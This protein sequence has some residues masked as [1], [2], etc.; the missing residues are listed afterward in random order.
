MVVYVQVSTEARRH[1][2]YLG[3][4][5]CCVDVVGLIVPGV[6][7]CLPLSARHCAALI[8]RYLS[9]NMITTITPGAL[10]NLPALLTL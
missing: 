8:C 6:A 4:M 9:R 2:R 3:H 10:S 1:L 5:A 7:L